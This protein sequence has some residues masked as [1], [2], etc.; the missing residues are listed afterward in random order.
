MRD[1]KI[2]KRL[3]DTR[4]SSPIIQL[5]PE[6][7]LVVFSDLHM[8]AGGRNDDF[9]RNGAFF[10]RVLETHYLPRGYT[11]VLNGD[12]EE[13]LR[14]HMKGIVQE[15]K[16]LYDVYTKFQEFGRFWKIEGNHDPKSLQD[17]STFD[18]QRGLRIML[19]GGEIFICHGHQGGYLNS[20]QY[21]FVQAGLLRLFANTFGIKNF[22]PAYYL[23]VRYKLEER[24]YRYATG[25]SIAMVIGHTHRPLFETRSKTS[26]FEAHLE[27]LC[28][29]W[30]K[31]P[32]S[33]REEIEKR[34][35]FMRTHYLEHIHSSSKDLPTGLYNKEILVPSLFNSGCCIGKR[36][37]TG[38][39]ISNDK[40]RLI[41]WSDPAIHPQSKIHW[42]YLSTREVAPNLYRTVIRKEATGRIMSRI[43]LLTERIE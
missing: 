11:L 16:S 41:H 40:M 34:I 36:G 8:G 24:L 20:G 30:I 37:I 15:W 43:K 25:E 27:H 28:K 9:R 35:I 22:S 7:K 23:P 31:S 18:I 21:N 26:E 19:E 13:L 32:V 3:D 2:Y 39:E 33:E 29:K 10:K 42:E 12:V 1:A 17:S 38:L 5:Q 6:E 14:H 4:R